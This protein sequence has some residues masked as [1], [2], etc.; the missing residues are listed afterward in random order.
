MYTTEI[1]RDEGTGRISSLRQS[2]HQAAEAPGARD[3][4]R[5]DTYDSDHNADERVSRIEL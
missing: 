4:Q 2:T 5:K 3:A 1:H